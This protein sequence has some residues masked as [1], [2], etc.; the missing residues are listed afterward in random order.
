MCIL[1]LLRGFH[2]DHPIVVGANRDERTDRKA[3]PPGLWVGAHSRVLSPRDR[4]ASGTW[5]AVDARG[6]FAGITNIVGVARVPDAPSRGHLPHLALEQRDL[7]AAVEAVV[8]FVR[9]H[10]HSGFQL[11]LCDGT[12]TVVLR[13]ARGSLRVVEWTDPVLVVTNEH[14]PGELKLRGLPGVLAP[15]QEVERRLDALQPLLADRGGEGRHAVCKRG[16]G[17]GTVSS[18]LIAVPAHD[19]L[20][21]LWR[22]APGPPDVTPYRNYGN[23]GRMLLPDEDF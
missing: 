5:L 4:E 23:L 7:D 9:E 13:Q 8:A 3:S 10:P 1:I 12:R 11:V 14:A 16:D 21:L 22:Y 19:P 17:Y 18:S 2:Q 6:R 15:M 20:A